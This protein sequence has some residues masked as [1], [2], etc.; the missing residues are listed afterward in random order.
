MD[1]LECFDEDDKRE[2]REFFGCYLLLS[3]NP[4]HRGCTYI[5]FTVNPNRRIRQHN[6]GRVKGGAKSTSG[7]G[8]WEMVL[9][10]HGFP[11]AISAL[12]FEWAWQNPNLSRRLKQRIQQN[13]L[14][15]PKF[16]YR[17]RVLSVMLCNGPWNRLGLTIRWIKQDYARDFVGT[18]LS[19][20]L[21][22][23]IAFGPV[24]PQSHHDTTFIQRD[25]SGLCGLCSKPF[26][27]DSPFGL[28]LFCPSSCKSGRWH[29]SCLARY[30][31]VG[32]STS[33]ESNFLLPLTATCPS[34]GEI[35]LLWPSLI[36]SWKMLASAL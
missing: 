36:S 7:R 8:P 17:L 10:I 32:H 26:Q 31:T 12:R 22:M 9:I 15:E 28:P 11:N 18:L 20:P 1:G 3:L 33:T 4:K 30:M 21:H 34:C 5:G 27:V 14:H 25:Y 29:L 16:D 6:A 24:S 23:P 13:Q 35:E 2:F 19:P